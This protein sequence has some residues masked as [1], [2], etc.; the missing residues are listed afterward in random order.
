MK[1]TI[2]IA[3]IALMAGAFGG[4]NCTPAQAAQAVSQAVTYTA[5]NGN[6]GFTSLSSGAGD[7]PSSGTLTFDGKGH[8]TGVMSLWADG[9]VCSGMTLVGT[10][11]VNP[12]LASGSAT[13]SLTSVNT[14]GCALSGNGYTLPVAITIANSGNTIYLA[15]MDDYTTNFFATAFDAFGAVATHY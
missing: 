5:L 13:M 2:M 9:D 3:S 4:I 12:G 7:Y 14:G 11:T 15:E 6:Y 10:Y 8:V 1:K